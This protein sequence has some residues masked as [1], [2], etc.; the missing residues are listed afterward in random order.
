MQSPPVYGTSGNDIEQDLDGSGSTFLYG[1]DDVVTLRASADGQQHLYA[2]KGADTAHLE[3]E[4]ITGWAM[5]HHIRM[6][7]Y[8]STTPMTSV[9]DA[10]TVNFRSFGSVSG[11]VVGRLEDYDP[12][13]DIIQVNG[14]AIDFQ[15]LPSNVEL[16]WFNGSYDDAEATDQMWIKIDTGAGGTLLYSLEGARIDMDGTGSVQNPDQELHFV[17]ASDLPSNLDDLEE[18]V[19][20]SEFKLPE[21]IVPDGYSAGSNG[22]VINDVDDVPAD[23]SVAINGS[24]DRDLIAAGI[25]DDT[26]YGKGGDDHI[27]AG[28][29]DDKVY[30]G[31]GDDTIFGGSGNDQLE[32]W[33]GNDT[34]E[35]GYGND[36]LKGNNGNDILSG[37][38][39]NDSLLGGNGNDTLSGGSGV[40]FLRG[41]E[42][43]DIMTGGSGTDTFKF[44]DGDMVDLAANQWDSSTIDLITDFIIGQDKI[45]FDS[46]TGISQLSDLKAWKEVIN[47]DDHFVLMEKTSK[48]A[49]LVNV[50]EGT[51]WSQFMDSSNFDF[52]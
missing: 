8:Q 10:D 35:G 38:G 37:S 2:G 25:N 42:L 20:D 50:D 41:G 19:I 36:L 33:A 43:K 13:R 52:G 9:S 31:S 1:G 22:Y 28:S 44:N 6:D 34:I 26:V 3:F 12:S 40:D 32:G 47:G 14:A 39:G 5:G 24:S 15:N 51:T 18:V 21:N 45:K 29:G 23:V 46:N 49:V 4:A 16:V 27:W 17:A 30:G 48:E 11:T 7:N